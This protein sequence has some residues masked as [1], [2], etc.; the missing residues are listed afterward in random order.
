MWD[1]VGIAPI[2]NLNTQLQEKLYLLISIV[3]SVCVLPDLD[4]CSHLSC[5]QTFQSSDLDDGSYPPLIP[6]Q[7]GLAL[8][9]LASKSYGKEPTTLLT[10]LS[11]I[12]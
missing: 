8:T 3:V 12:Q 1:Y 10:Y 6:N 7:P 5:P 4:R 9:D 2:R 11:K